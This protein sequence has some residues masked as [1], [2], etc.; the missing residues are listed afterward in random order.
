[1]GEFQDLIVVYPLLLLFNLIKYILIRKGIIKRKQYYIDEN[2]KKD[3]INK[4]IDK[5]VDT[6]PLGSLTLMTLGFMIEAYW[7]YSIIG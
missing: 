3:I 4:S 2:Y 7:V 5:F 6:Y 1:M